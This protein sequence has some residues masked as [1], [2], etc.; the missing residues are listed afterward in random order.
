MAA[1]RI[2]PD[3]AYENLISITK[4]FEEFCSLKGSVSEADTRAKVIDAILK[5]VCGWPEK[6]ICRETHTGNGYL[7]YLLSVQAIDCRD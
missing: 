7:D 4:E 3:R 6:Q 1:E 2:T 5:N